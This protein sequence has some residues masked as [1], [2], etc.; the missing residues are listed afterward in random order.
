[1]SLL[2]GET[3]EAGYG[4]I[5]ILHGIDIRVEDGEM[6]AVLG[7]N[8]AGKSTLM[9]T[10]AGIL[11]L[12]KGRL[13]FEEKDITTIKQH[14][15]AKMK[16][17]YVPQEKNVFPDLTVA[18]N[19]EMGAFT[20]KNPKQAIE[21][22]Y[23]RFP[24]LKERN[25]QKADTLSGGERQL[26]AVSSALL[27]D[28]KLLILD[29]PTSGL[30]PQATESMINTISR[31]R[32]EGKAVIW[33]VEENPKEVLAHVDRVYLIESGVIRKEGTGGEF[34]ENE[35]EFE[36]LFLGHNIS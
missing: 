35:E 19:L 28:P 33:V 16:L 1:M 20:L 12:M 2:K 31:I 15:L 8:G 18:E 13:F 23:E 26:L 22:I 4:K 29:E 27:L 11:P 5:P 14:S 7:A 21:A 34:L 17:G 30:S 10:I 25:K 24:K 6:V 3:I 9:K 36:K 32:D